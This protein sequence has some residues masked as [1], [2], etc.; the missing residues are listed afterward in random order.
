M[1]RALGAY[2]GDLK[3][4]LLSREAMARGD[5][6]GP[7]LD[8]GRFDFDGPAASAAAQMMMVARGTKPELALAI[9]AEHH[10]NF[11][12]LDQSLEGSIDGRQ[13]DGTTLAADDLAPFLRALELVAAGECRDHGQPLSCS[14][15]PQNPRAASRLGNQRISHA[16]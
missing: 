7:A 8:L 12:G 2:A 4:V 11:A 10:V 15:W 9:V 1:V 6:P 14:A 3:C 16:R 5:G 13:P